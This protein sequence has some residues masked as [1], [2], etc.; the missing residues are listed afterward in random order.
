MDCRNPGY[1]DVLGLPS[2]ALDTRFP[3]GMTAFVYNGM[4]S[5]GTQNWEGRKAQSAPPR[6]PN[7]RLTQVVYRNRQSPRRRSKRLPEAVSAGCPRPMTVI[8]HSAG[9][10]INFFKLKNTPHFH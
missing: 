4:A 6:L 9:A 1:K 2:L 10:A 3:A 7:P 5:M 8:G